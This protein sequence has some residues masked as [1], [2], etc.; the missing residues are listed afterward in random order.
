MPTYPASGC[1]S[2]RADEGPGWCSIA[3]KDLEDPDIFA[4]SLVEDLTEYPPDVLAQ[5]VK[6]TRRTAEVEPADCGMS[7]GLREAGCTAAPVG[8]DLRVDSTRAGSAPLPCE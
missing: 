1:A 3:M 7:R 8:S 2:P 6:Q 5:M 4:R